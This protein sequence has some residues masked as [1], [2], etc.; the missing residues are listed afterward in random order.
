MIGWFDSSTGD[1]TWIAVVVASGVVTW[2]EVVEKL[3]GWA[4]ELVRVVLTMTG[5]VA[6]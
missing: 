4:A 1:G 5:C 2:S 6:S 3:V